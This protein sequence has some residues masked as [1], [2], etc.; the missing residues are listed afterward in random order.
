MVNKSRG[1]VAPGKRQTN[2]RI[3]ED[4]IL[5]LEEEAQRRGFATLPALVNTIFAERYA[6][7]RSK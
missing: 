4:T 7:E 3:R 2:W 1:A 5:H 6:G